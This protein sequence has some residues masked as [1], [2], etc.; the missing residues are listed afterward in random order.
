MEQE[1][2]LF[3]ACYFFVGGDCTIESVDD[4][5]EVTESEEG[6]LQES[7]IV[8]KVVKGEIDGVLDV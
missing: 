7:G 2:V 6:D 4:T 1:F 5:S 3:T 8:R